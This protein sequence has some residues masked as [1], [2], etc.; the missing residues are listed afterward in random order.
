M[1]KLLSTERHFNLQFSSHVP[2]Y[3]FGGAHFNR[4]K[5]ILR[6]EILERVGERMI[7]KDGIE[8]IPHSRVCLLG[9]AADDAY[10]RPTEVGRCALVP[11]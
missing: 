6:R 5:V 10:R 2:P 1:S 9:R 8:C 3:T 4:P 11:R 7:D